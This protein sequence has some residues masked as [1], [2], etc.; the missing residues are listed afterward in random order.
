[1]EIVDTSVEARKNGMV[2]D[3]SRVLLARIEETLN[4]GGK[5]LILRPWGPFDDLQEQI[6]RVFPDHSGRVY[7]ATVHEARR[8]DIG[9]VS[10]LALMNADAL[11]D[12][13]DFRADEKAMQTLEQFRGRLPGH[14]LVQTR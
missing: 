14:M 9:D 10:L 4:D 6:G 2:G 3:L 12:K 11:M 8:K 5:V 1:M 13:H 7:F